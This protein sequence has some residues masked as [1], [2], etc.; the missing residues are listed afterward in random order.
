M[1]RDGDRPM[2][3]SAT[4]PALGPE[5]PGFVDEV[6]KALMR[7]VR[8]RL[9]ISIGYSYLKKVSSLSELDDERLLRFAIFAV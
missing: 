6:E 8:S 5:V 7:L 2:Y 3:P 1:R 9:K 4:S